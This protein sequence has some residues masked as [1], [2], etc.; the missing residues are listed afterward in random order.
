MAKKA[1]KKRLKQ[2]QVMY[3]ANL[4]IKD[5]SINQADKKG[6]EVFKQL[7]K[8]LKDEFDLEFIFEGVEEL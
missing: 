6:Q 5:R 3:S 1:K 8:R 4:F 7:E 2:Y